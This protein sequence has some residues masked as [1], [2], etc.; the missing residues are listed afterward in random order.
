VFRANFPRAT[1]ADTRTLHFL[2]PESICIRLS[3]MGANFAADFLMYS[4][5]LGGANN[6]EAQLKWYMM[7]QTKPELN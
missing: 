4:L 6:K 2:F 1:G 3:I 7:V 5:L